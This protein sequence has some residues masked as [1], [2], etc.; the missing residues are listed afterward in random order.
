MINKPVSERKERFLVML[1]LVKCHYTFII[2]L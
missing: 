2:V 1:E